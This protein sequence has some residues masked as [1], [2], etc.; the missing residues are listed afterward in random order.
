MKKKPTQKDADK[1][2]EAARKAM[3]AAEAERKKR[4]LTSAPAAFTSLEGEGGMVEPTQ[5][6]SETAVKSFKEGKTDQLNVRVT[7]TLLAELRTL[8]KKHQVTVAAIVEAGC[9][10]QIDKLRSRPAPPPL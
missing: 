8:A 3:E 2:R 5:S 1:A 7:A 4:N 6:P 9:R 10:H